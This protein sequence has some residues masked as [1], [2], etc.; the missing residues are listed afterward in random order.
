LD[1]RD[2]RL[3]GG[4]DKLQKVLAATNQQPAGASI[5]LR[6]EPDFSGRRDC[7]AGIGDR[8][9]A[10]RVGEAWIAVYENWLSSQVSRGENRGKAAVPR[11][12]RARADGPFA[13]DRDGHAQPRHTVRSGPDWSLKNVGVAVLVQ[14][15]DSGEYLQATL[16]PLACGS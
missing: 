6:V 4:M 10:P 15:K 16:T 9:S 8:S 11:L 7:R 3:I 5:E 1:G 13:I 12:R 14:R 2:L